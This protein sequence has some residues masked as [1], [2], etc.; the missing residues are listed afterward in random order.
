MKKPFF[1]GVLLISSLVA[2]Q[3][4]KTV[5]DYWKSHATKKD[6]LLE[7]LKTDLKG[8]YI[9]YDGKWEG[10][11]EFA[12]WRR[13]NGTDL[14]GQTN[15]G[16]GPACTT[17]SVTF[18]E[19]S[20]TDVTKKVLPAI[21]AAQEKAMQALY[22]QKTSDSVEASWYLKFPQKGTT[23]LVRSGEYSDADV[24]LGSYTFNGSSFVFVLAK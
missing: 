1:I 14:I 17:M 23:I 13:K 3:S 4:K 5:A 15:H 6:V 2:A 18:W 8:D 10:G 9:S 20:K 16:C 21:T 7:T 19:A 22:K 24:V 11:G 12:V